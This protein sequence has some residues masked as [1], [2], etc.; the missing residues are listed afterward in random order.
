MMTLH[1]PNSNIENLNGLTGPPGQLPFHAVPFADLVHFCN[2]DV[3]SQI[4]DFRFKTLKKKWN[5]LQASMV[6]YNLWKDVFNFDF[7]ENSPF[8]PQ[9]QSLLDACVTLAERDHKIEDHDFCFMLNNMAPASYSAITSTI[10][11]VSPMDL[12]PHYI[13]EHL[14]NEE[15]LH[16][17]SSSSISGSVNKIALVK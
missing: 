9:F 11:A 10:L 13:Q 12:T 16:T 5:E 14:L 15:G 6:T 4:P 7:N 8:R 17:G 1:A 3:L 2:R